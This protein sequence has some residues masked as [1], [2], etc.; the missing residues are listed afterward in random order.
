MNRLD[1]LVSR[2]FAPLISRQVRAALALTEED[3]TFM[4]GTR[5]LSDS[6]RD[7]PAGD[8]DEILRQSL[9]AWQ[10]NPLA[11][12]LVALTSQYVVGGG[13][14]IGC[15][16]HAGTNAFL[17]Q[18][19]A[20]PLNRMP[21]RLYEWCDEL[22]RS[23]N[24]FL[25]LS[26]DVAGMSYLRA[27]P[28]SQIAGI[29]SAGN[30]LEQPRAFLPKASLLDPD[31]RPWQ[32]YDPLND[33]LTGEPGTARGFTTVMLHYAINRPVGAQWGE[34]D[35]AP[36]LRWLSRY[37]GWLEDRARLNRF[38]TAFMYVVRNRFTSEA[39]RV[40]RQRSLNSHPPTPGSIL[41][42]DSNEDWSVI[43]PQLQAD[44]AGS[45]GLAL[46]KMI[47]AG[48][49]VPLHFLAEPESA[50][51]TTAEA[52]GGPTFRHYEQ[53]QKFFTWLISDVLRAVLRRRALLD[54]RVD[55]SAELQVNGGDISS[56]DNIALAMAAANLISSLETLR[57]RSLIDDAEMLRLLYRFLD[58]PLDVAAMLTRGKAAEKTG[59]DGKSSRAR[60]PKQPLGSAGELRPSLAG[61]TLS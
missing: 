29:E 51:R 52:S 7:R 31:A 44:E 4:V 37:A 61:E 17:Q 22:T 8:R 42:S 36:L 1:A 2:W 35:L 12:R 50:T 27:V 48:A 28:A 10:V 13:I 40:A 57:D 47:A 38:R 46:K 9:E 56:R 30:D 58:E 54:T 23:G 20:H 14:S 25:L 49:G 41:V 16:D 33:S 45:D 60:L 3:N 39:E 18:F 19:W 11:R 5:A 59:G 21:V 32:A 26:T 15:R 43:N 6:E 53:R 55:A 24:L 34:S